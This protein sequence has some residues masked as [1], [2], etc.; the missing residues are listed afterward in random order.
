MDN[1][2]Y[3]DAE[4]LQMRNFLKTNSILIVAIYEKELPLKATLVYEGTNYSIKQ[5]TTQEEKRTRSPLHIYVCE[6]VHG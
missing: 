4:N 3:I 1:T 6:A 2:I 5:H